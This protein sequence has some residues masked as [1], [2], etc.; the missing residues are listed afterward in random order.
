MA[1]PS[2]Y[3]DIVPDAG[4]IVSQ[5]ITT[6]KRCCIVVNAATIGDYATCYTSVEI[7]R[8]LG[9]IRTT[10]RDISAFGELYLQHHAAWEVLDPGTYT[11]FLVNHATASK[12]IYAAWLKIIASDCEG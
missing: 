6:T 4:I 7:E 5:A 12:H 2:I 9:T 3:Y 11:Y 8:P 10:Q 1:F